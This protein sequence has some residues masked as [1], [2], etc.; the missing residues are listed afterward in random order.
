MT[1]RQPQYLEEIA[2]KIGVSV[3]DVRIRDSY[4]DL[5]PGLDIEQSE[6]FA[7]EE[8]AQA[9]RRAAEFFQDMADAV[10]HVADAR[11]R[12]AVQALCWNARGV[13]EVMAHRAEEL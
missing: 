7:G 3:E 5:L 6:A 10:N 9:L 11:T 1:N 2:R 8:D 4:G 12:M 13:A